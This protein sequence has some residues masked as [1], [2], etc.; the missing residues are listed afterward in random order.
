MHCSNGDKSI[1]QAAPLESS[2][3]QFIGQDMSRPVNELT[4]LMEGVFTMK[5]DAEAASY[6][7]D[8]MK[9]LEVAGKSKQNPYYHSAFI[10][11]GYC[12]C[13]ISF[14]GDTRAGRQI[15]T[16]PARSSAAGTAVVRSANISLFCE[17]VVSAR[18]SL[19]YLFHI[20]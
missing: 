17:H 18:S 6:N 13:A 7:H 12:A 3:F 1:F 19:V 15:Q 8:P 11:G 14:G 2:L 10:N 9:V 16:I 5:M 4:P 20:V